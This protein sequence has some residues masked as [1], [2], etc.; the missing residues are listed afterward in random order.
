[1][2]STDGTLR[3]ATIDDEPAIRALLRM[4]FDLQGGAAVVVEADGSPG[5][6]DAVVAERPDVVLLDQELDGVRGTELIGDLSRRCPDAM[7]AMLSASVG[8]EDTALRAGAFAC[9]PKRDLTVAL[10]AQVA[11]D[12]DRFAVAHLGAMAQA[13]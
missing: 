10:P 11:A 8:V 5:S 2:A 13:V 3:V 7:I 4:T 12:H 9:Y 1:M 6:L